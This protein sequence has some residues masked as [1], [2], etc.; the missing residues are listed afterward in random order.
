MLTSNKCDG[1]ADLICNKRQTDNASL[2]LK[3]INATYMIQPSSI[4][5]GMPLSGRLG[6]API[7]LSSRS[8]I[9]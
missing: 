2:E 5:H 4:L 9:V 1:Q 6:L 3:P 8:W 7:Q